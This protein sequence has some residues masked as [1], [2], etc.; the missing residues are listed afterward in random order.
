MKKLFLIL[1]LILNSWFMVGCIEPK[2]ETYHHVHVI[3]CGYSQATFILQDK[4]IIQLYS[5]YNCAVWN[6]STYW[7]I[8]VTYKSSVQ[9]VAMEK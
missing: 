1:F 7:T 2:V 5:S 8:D 9:D 6:Y 4:S 3:G